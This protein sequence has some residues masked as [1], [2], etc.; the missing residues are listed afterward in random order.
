MFHVYEPN[1]HYLCRDLINPF[2]KDLPEGVLLFPS[3]LP[4]ATFILLPEEVK[5]IKGGALLV[6]RKMGFLHPTLKAKLEARFPLM[7]DV[8][9]GTICL[10]LPDDITGRDFD[11]ICKIFYR[12]IYE[13]LV[14][15]GIKERTSF[16]C[17]TLTSIEQLSTEV[18][19]FWPY[20]LGVRADESSDGLF[21]GILSLKG[22]QL[23]TQ[24]FWR[25]SEFSNQEM[26][27]CEKKGGASHG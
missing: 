16:V 11:S 19:G 24:W 10:Q 25:D 2:L 21:H 1:E 12:M 4:Q 8:W 6:K 17:L 18:M 9:T 14:A 23:E 27:L 3:D 13:D 22:S 7:Q 15:F 26:S 5:P 20:V